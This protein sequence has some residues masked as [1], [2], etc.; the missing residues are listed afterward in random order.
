MPSPELQLCECGCGEPAPIATRNRRDRG[1]VAGRPMRFIAHH[2]VRLLAI[3]PR[4]A[5]RVAAPAPAIAPVPSPDLSGPRWSSAVRCSRRAVYEGLGVQGEPFSEETLSY[6]RRGRMLGRVLAEELDAQLA[7]AGRPPGEA[8]RLIPWPASDPIGVGHADYFITDEAEI[9]ENV[10]SEGCE[11]PGHKALQ[12]AGYV[13]NDPVATKGRVRS[14]DPSSMADRDYPIDAEGLREQVERIE[15][16]VVAGVRDGVLPDRPEGIES[17]SQGLCFDCPMRRPCWKTWEPPPIGTLPV[18][19]HGDV[20]RLADLED[21]I[22]RF[23]KVPHLEAER[24]EIREKLV[25]LMIE[26]ALYRGNGISVKWTGVEGRR[27]FRLA[28]YEK[29]GHSL[30]RGGPAEAFTRVGK[31]HRHWT[32]KR[33]EDA[34]PYEGDEAA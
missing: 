15:R 27:S 18:S 8:E 12:N 24:E 25:G 17:P 11:L 29:A 20:T 9:I 26:G 33:L 14:I 30:D 19:V 16:E 32:V 2:H 28:D 13:I 34:D 10:S 7:A 31:G 3:V 4:G 5:T 6:M 1:H 23:K 22:G 21:E